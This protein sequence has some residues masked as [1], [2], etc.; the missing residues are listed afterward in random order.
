MD[1][2]DKMSQPETKP[3]VAVGIQLQVQVSD[4]ATVMLQ[5]HVD[6]ENPEERNRSLDLVHACAERLHYRYRQTALAR[7]IQ[8]TELRLAAEQAQAVKDQAAYELDSVRR[9]GE[10]DRVREDD[11][12]TFTTSDRRGTYKPNAKAVQA[13]NRI[14]QEQTRATEQH[15]QRVEIST[16]NIAKFTRDLEMR[17]AER[18]QLEALLNGADR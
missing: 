7:M 13:V 2:M 4:T 3:S 15:E 12:A 6:R 5:T 10:L 18:A 8:E 1:G 11:R 14:E 9:A 16:T 17:Q